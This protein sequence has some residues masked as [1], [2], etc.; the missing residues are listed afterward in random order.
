MLVYSCSGQCFV[1]GGLRVAKRK[2]FFRA[3]N[4][5]RANC[6]YFFT[7]TVSPLWFFFAM[8]CNTLHLIYISKSPAFHFSTTAVSGL[9]GRSPSPTSCRESALT[10]S[11]PRLGRTKMALWWRP[12]PRFLGH[13]FAKK[14]SISTQRH[15]VSLVNIMPTREGKKR[16]VI[17]TIPRL[18]HSACDMAAWISL[19]L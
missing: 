17:S 18:L 10:T 2:K 6:I 1:N 11:F 12:T 13:A 14:N 8:A 3:D 15:D 5:T 16:N 9:L 19:E 7:H 4:L